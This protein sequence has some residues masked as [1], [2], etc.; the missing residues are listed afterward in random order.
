[1]GQYIMV[2]VAIGMGIQTLSEDSQVVIWERG[3]IISIIMTIFIPNNQE[4]RG[5][6]VL[7]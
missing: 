3:N 6:F 7:L 5:F 2:A 4:K 1:M